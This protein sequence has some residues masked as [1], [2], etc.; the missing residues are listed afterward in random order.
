MKA[1]VLMAPRSIK[2]NERDKPIIGPEDVLIKV[3]AVG[4]CGSDLHYYEHGRIG[5]RVVRKPLVQGHEC[6][7]MVVQVGEN[8]KN[9]KLNDRVVIEPGLPCGLCPTCKEGTY[10]LCDDVLFLST[11]PNDGVLKEYLAHPAH[12]TYKIPDHVSNEVATLAEPLSVGIYAAQKL[13]LA[14]NTHVVIM[15]MGPAGLCMILAAKWF[16]AK[17][18]SVT[19]VEPFRLEIA[20]QIGATHGIQIREDQ[21]V[22]SLDYHAEMLGGYDCVIDTTGKDEALEWAV[23]LLKRGGKIGGIGFPAK[24]SSAMP[25]LK[26]IQKEVSYLP[27]YRYRNT[28]EQAIELL[29]QDQDS[30]RKLLTD[31]Y[32]MSEVQEAFHHALSQKDK[33]IKVIVYPER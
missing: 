3:K 23:R 14:P 4:I 27:I 26:M 29:S 30:A 20:K 10:N 6:A 13:Q 16:G 11:P 18:I 2:L 9:L 31:F 17:T 33:S 28:F 8:V 7:G 1:A 32:A 5:D 22:H 21:A 24:S 25:L 15:G 12:F 19:D